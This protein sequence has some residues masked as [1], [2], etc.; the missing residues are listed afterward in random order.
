[1]K[2][3]TVAAS[4]AVGMVKWANMYEAEGERGE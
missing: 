4:W 3:P 2:V 1:M